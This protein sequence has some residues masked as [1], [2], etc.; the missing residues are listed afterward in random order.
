M[1]FG[2]LP[3]RLAVAEFLIFPAAVLLGTVL[4]LEKRFAAEGSHESRSPGDRARKGS[5]L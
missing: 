4:E 2:D 3:T 5:I 1:A